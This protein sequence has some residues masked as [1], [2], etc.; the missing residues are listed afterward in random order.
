MPKFQSYKFSEGIKNTKEVVAVP[1]LFF[2]FGAKARLSINT[3]QNHAVAN[4]SLTVPSF[5]GCVLCHTILIQY[6]T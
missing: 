2:A 1:F 5:T 3:P 6:G 4:L